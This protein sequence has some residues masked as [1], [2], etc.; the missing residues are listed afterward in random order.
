MTSD[1]K[2]GEFIIDFANIYEITLIS[3]DYVDGKEDVIL[4]YVPIRG[5]D[6]VFS[7]SIPEKNMVKSGLRKLLTVGQIEQLLKDLRSQK[8]E[9]YKYITQ[10]TKEK[11]YLNL[12]D[13]IVAPLKFLWKNSTQYPKTDLELRD[14]M[15]DHLSLEIVFVTKEPLSLVKKKIEENLNK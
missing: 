8:I 4:H 3:T 15:I 9:E 14:K 13:K 5:T 1:F 7:A 6:K 11:M 12:P 2:V 10:E